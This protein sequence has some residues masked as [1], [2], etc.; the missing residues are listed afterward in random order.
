MKR[1]ALLAGLALALAGTAAADTLGTLMKNTLTLTDAQGG[2]TTIRLSDNGRMEQVDAAGMW[3]EGAWAMEE[4]GLCWTARGKARVCI[5]L[6][7]G[8]DIGDRWEIRGPTGQVV[9][10]AAIL[11]GRSAA[12]TEARK[13][14]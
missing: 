13:P 6:E 4:R 12:Q 3:A 14:E 9:V 1:A 7:D 2:V 10:T 11:E 8:K 5:P